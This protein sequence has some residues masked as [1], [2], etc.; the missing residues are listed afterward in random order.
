MTVRRIVFSTSK[1]AGRLGRDTT[2]VGEAVPSGSEQTAAASPDEA[3]EVR[4]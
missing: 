3:T 2:L 1:R 4:P